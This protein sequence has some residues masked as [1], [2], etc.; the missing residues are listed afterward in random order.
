MSLNTFSA[1]TRLISE[2]HHLYERA[3]RGVSKLVTSTCKAVPGAQR[4]IR[5]KEEKPLL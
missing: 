5:T 4:F 2:V 3:G 1:S